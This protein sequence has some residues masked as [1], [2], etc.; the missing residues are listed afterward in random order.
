MNGLSKFSYPA[1]FDVVK[2]DDIKQY[3]HIVSRFQAHENGN[4]F[5]EI[6]KGNVLVPKAGELGIDEQK[7]T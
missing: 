3:E 6:M 4:G 1:K 2:P 7:A 5:G